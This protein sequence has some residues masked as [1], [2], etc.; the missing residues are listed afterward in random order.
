[1]L[2]TYPALELPSRIIQ[3]TRA[4]ENDLVTINNVVQRAVL[5]WPMALRMKRRAVTVLQYDRIDMQNYVFYRYSTG[6]TVIGAIAI[7]FELSGSDASTDDALLHGIFVDPDAQ[8][9]GVG[10]T[11]LRFAERQ[12][13]WRSMRPAH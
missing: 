10:A 7:D 6:R 2:Q 13:R 4:D 5:N 3:F 12:A 8:S 9:Q 1:M 11:L